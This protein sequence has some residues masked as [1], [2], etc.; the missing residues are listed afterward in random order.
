MTLKINLILWKN[1]LIEAIGTQPRPVYIQSLFHSSLL[2]HLI[3]PH[4]WQVVKPIV[5][6]EPSLNKVVW[7]KHLN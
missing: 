6:Y 5:N 1:V 7:C 4:V 2:P 3:N